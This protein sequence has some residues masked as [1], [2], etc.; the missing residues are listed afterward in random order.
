VQI[1]GQVFFK[2]EIMTKN[3]KLG[4]DLIKIVFSITGPILT[5]PCTDHP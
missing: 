1:K 4:W 5:R 3:A 2:E